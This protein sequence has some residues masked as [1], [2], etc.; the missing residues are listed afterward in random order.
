MLTAFPFW[1]PFEFKPIVCL[2]NELKKLSFYFQLLDTQVLIFLFTSRIEF[3]F[4]KLFD[5]QRTTT[6]VIREALKMNINITHLIQPY[7]EK[8]I[9][10]A[11]EHNL[12][13]TQ[14]LISF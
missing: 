2:E 9:L 8:G 3:N 6:Q 11:N 5:G 13:R 7:M 14:P 1:A 10:I 12:S 4:C